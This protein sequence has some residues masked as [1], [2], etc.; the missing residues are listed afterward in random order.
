LRHLLPTSRLLHLTRHHLLHHR[1]H[2]LLLAGILLF[3]THLWSKSPV[4]AFGNHWSGGFLREGI[5]LFE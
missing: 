1:H 5:E 3:T 4:D 2:L